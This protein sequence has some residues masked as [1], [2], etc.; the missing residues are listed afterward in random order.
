GVGQRCTQLWL[1][2]QRFDLQ[3]ISKRHPGHRPR[4]VEV[5]GEDVGVVVGSGGVQENWF[6]G[7][8]GV[9]HNGSLS[10]GE[11][12]AGADSEVKRTGSS[13]RP[14][15]LLV[16]SQRCSAGGVAKRRSASRSKATPIAV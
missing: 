1:V 10:A 3:P 8:G 7:G 11:G 5:R 15:R 9:L 4:R 16:G 6:P 14:R 13:I 2:G 12:T